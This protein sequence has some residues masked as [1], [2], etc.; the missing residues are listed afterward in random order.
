M[1][2]SYVLPSNTSPETYPKNHAS[3]YTTPLNDPLI[4]EGQW[5]VACLSVYHNNC[6]HT[7]NHDTLTVLDRSGN[8]THMRKP[9]RVNFPY[10]K[11]PPVKSFLQALN[12]ALTGIVTFKLDKDLHLRYTFQSK[13]FILYLSPRLAKNF[14]TSNVLTDYDNHKGGHKALD[15]SQFDEMY[16]IPIPK[17]YKHTRI[18]LKVPN[19]NVTAQ[20]LIQRFR[21]RVT[22]KLPHLTLT[23]NEN[24][25]HIILL[26]SRP[27]HQAILFSP[28]LHKNSG[29]RQNGIDFYSR[30][31][32]WYHHDFNNIFPDTWDFLIYDVNN[33]EVYDGILKYPIHLKPRMFQ[34]ENQLC[35]YLMKKINH[36][37]IELK[38]TK[39]KHAE[40]HIKKKEISLEFGSDLRDI[41]GFDQSIYHGISTIQ[42]SGMISMTRRI[43]YI[44]VYS[45]VGDL[46]RIG[47]TEAPLLCHFPFNPQPCSLITERMFKKPTYVKV[48]NPRLSHITIELYDDAGQ[49]IPFHRDA[50]TT[51]R[52]HFRRA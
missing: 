2:F 37:Q 20:E 52:L 3:S 11:V 9:M 30:Q 16:V 33:V 22:S 34:N 17:T 24:S 12:T 38:A 49:L 46:V 10:D 39:E 41:L 40:L 4:L 27:S 15:I 5:E 13:D 25:T 32:R 48:I 21:D 42:S 43:N 45:N 36:N 47:D 35:T 6:I 26:N 31:N 29:Y 7:L 18:S 28:D 19:E 1:S 8:I 23:S 50:M 44:Y 14:H 51:L